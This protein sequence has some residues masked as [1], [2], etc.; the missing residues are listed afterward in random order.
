MKKSFC[1]YSR[2]LVIFVI[3]ILIFCNTGCLK[4]SKSP[5]PQ[6][7][8]SKMKMARVPSESFESRD[9]I[10][11]Q[12]EK[13]AGSTITP[14]D[15]S[16]PVSISRLIVKTGNINI[17]VREVTEAAKK[18]TEYVES[19]NGW[20]V[21]SNIYEQNEIPRGDITV[22]VPA[23]LFDESM[24]YFESIA[25]KV[26]SIDVQGEDVT[27]E[28][29]DLES[30]MK[31]LSATEEQLLKIMKRSGKI[32]EVLEVVRELNRIR[33]QKERTIGRM[34]YLEGCARM[35]T[36]SIHLAPSR[37]LLPVPP[38]D[39]WRPINVMKKAWHSAL[40][41]LKALSYLVIWII[42]FG[43]IWVPI[44]FIIWFI[45]RRKK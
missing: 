43:I 39:K 22:R 25:E 31:T 12:D 7:L 11:A 10:M 26:T 29:V 14:G 23:E 27:E 13:M 34:Q 28:Y 41:F 40:G 17:V 32:S 37:D 36:I 3:S 19:K 18:I 42:V 9:K 35:S 21:S 1:T 2:I 45:K 24:K 8:E 6:S 15:E 4:A 20:V 16:S 5:S 30:R 38:S 33:E 44:I